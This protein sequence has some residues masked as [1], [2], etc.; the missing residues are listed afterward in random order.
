MVLKEKFVTMDEAR[1]DPERN[2]IRIKVYPQK[3][4]KAPFACLNRNF[5]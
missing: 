2:I 5:L 3:F 4:L 1:P